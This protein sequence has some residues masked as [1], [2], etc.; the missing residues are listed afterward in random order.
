M[1]PSECSLLN[2]GE[3]G[4]CRDG[5]YEPGGPP[6]PP[7]PP[8]TPLRP[9]PVFELVEPLEEEAVADTVPTAITTWSP[10]ESPEAISM[11]PSPLRPSVTVRLVDCPFCETVTVLVPPFVVIAA[12]GMPMTPLLLAVTT[13]TV[14]VMPDLRPSGTWSRVT[15]P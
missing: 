12:E 11:V 10:A 15:V 4:R 5:G 8:A 14:A 6:K 7:P 9:V 1:R 13:L 3:G 2:E